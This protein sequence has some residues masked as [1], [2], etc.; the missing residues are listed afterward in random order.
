MLHCCIDLVLMLVHITFRSVRKAFEKYS[1]LRIAA[2]LFESNSAPFH[3]IFE[4]FE[5]WHTREFSYASP[6]QTWHA[7]FDKNCAIRSTV[8][9]IALCQH[10]SP[11]SLIRLKNM[12]ELECPERPSVLC[13]ACVH[14]ASCTR[15]HGEPLVT[16][17]TCAGAVLE[18]FYGREERLRPHY[19]CASRYV[20]GVSMN[21]YP[22]LLPVPTG[23]VASFTFACR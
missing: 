10:R 23:F 11:R 6:V 9:Y 19:P 2:I 13:P 22:P 14:P 12:A 18:H 1:Y 5:Y 17:E 8:C 7:E 15:R 21:G 16:A 4:I 3:W 20:R